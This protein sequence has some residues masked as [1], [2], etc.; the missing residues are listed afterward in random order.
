MG[1]IA[2]QEKKYLSRYNEEINYIFTQIMGVKTI[3]PSTS[4][5]LYLYS[6]LKICSVCN[7][8]SARS[9]CKGGKFDEFSM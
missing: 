3:F 8:N 4:S 6:S 5:F 9:S 7:W 2:S 1:M